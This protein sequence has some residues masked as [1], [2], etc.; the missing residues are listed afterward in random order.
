MA[1][2]IK[3][4]AKSVFVTGAKQKIDEVSAVVRFIHPSFV[5]LFRPESDGFHGSKTLWKS[6]KGHET[7]WDSLSQFLSKHGDGLVNHTD[8]IQVIR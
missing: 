3:S 4:L 5:T 1:E 2:V 6:V 7:Y 8:E